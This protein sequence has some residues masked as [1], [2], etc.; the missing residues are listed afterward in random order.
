MR[1]TIRG[2]LY[3]TRTGTYICQTNRGKLYRKYHATE[4]F[5][6]AR[7][8]ITPLKWSEARELAY[9]FAPAN[10]YKDY[11]TTQIIDQKVRT[12]IDLSRIDMQKLKI[13]SGCHD[14]PP[15]QMLHKIIGEEYRKLD[16]HITEGTA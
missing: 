8:K 14:L 13:L 5:L 1:A 6:L 15:K 11:F 3:D 16:R 10:T 9:H 12:N 4:F 2:R 7:D